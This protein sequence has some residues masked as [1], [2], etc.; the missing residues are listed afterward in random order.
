M[1]SVVH[2]A[3]PSY[4]VGHS[5]IVFGVAEIEKVVQLLQQS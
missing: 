2:S 3:L 4:G 1:S 5:S